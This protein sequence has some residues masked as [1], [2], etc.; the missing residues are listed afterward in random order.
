MRNLAC[1][2]SRP[3]IT[4]CDR[5]PDTST[6]AFRPPGELRLGAAAAASGGV[7]AD[8]ALTRLRFYSY[9]LPEGDLAAEA[10]ARQPQLQQYF[11]LRDGEQA[12]SEVLVQLV[13]PPA[14]QDG[15]S[16]GNSGGGSGLP[17]A[18]LG[19]A[20]GGGL[21]LVAAAAGGIWWFCRRRRLQR[22]QHGQSWEAALQH[23][24]ADSVKS[25]Q[26][27]AGKASGGVLA[28]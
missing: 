22:E 8:A 28:L 21:T 5:A 17:G 26:A 18:M 10:A 3:S 27:A 1:V 2:P 14:Q 7:A 23:T 12:G 19:A 9:A 20:A 11:R 15:G 16:S 25:S 24:S 4:Y 13:S 6:D